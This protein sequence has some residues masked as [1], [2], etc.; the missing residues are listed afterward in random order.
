M[1]TIAYIV[2]RPNKGRIGNEMVTVCAFCHVACAL[3]AFRRIS[4]SRL[5]TQM[6][7]KVLNHEPYSLYYVCHVALYISV[8]SFEQT[9]VEITWF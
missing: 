6:S 1:S 7:L 2:H 4:V 8:F 5:N 9:Q 3:G